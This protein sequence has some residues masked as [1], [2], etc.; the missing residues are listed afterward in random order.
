MTAI[1]IAIAA[2]TLLFLS[3]ESSAESI[4]ALNADN[5]QRFLL[6]M[7]DV[8]KLGKKY[9]AKEKT[10]KEMKSAQKKY[11]AMARGLMTQGP[12][13]KNLERAVAPLSSGI[14]EMYESGGFDEMLVTVKR[15][16]F[17][18]VEQWA[19]IGDK[20]IRAYAA[21]KIGEQVPEMNK[22]MKEMKA[23]LAKSGMPAEQQEAMMEMMGAG[24]TIMES[25][26]DVPSADK[27]AI[28]P[29]ISQLENLGRR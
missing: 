9:S 10:G 7:D 14:P 29:F 4:P 3:L 6:S 2:T 24:S 13:K 28:K 27:K 11:E 25:F 20:A 5:I 26:N 19:G 22:Q 23:K 17:S 12:S 8:E 1:R 18:S 21:T 16:G 15:H